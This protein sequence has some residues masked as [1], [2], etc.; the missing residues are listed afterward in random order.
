[1]IYTRRDPLKP[2][3]IVK[4][5]FHIYRKSEVLDSVEK[6]LNSLKN[7][8][9]I[10]PD[11]KAKPI[12]KTRCK[13]AV[14]KSPSKSTE[15]TQRS[16]PVYFVSR[17]GKIT[18]EEDKADSTQLVLVLKPQYFFID[19]T[20]IT[21]EYSISQLLKTLQS[22]SDIF[23]FGS[24]KVV[25]SDQIQEHFQLDIQAFRKRLS[26]F[27]LVAK[28]LLRRKTKSKLGIGKGVE[29]YIPF[30]TWA[31]GSLNS[32]LVNSLV[33]VDKLSQL[34]ICYGDN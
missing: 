2:S 6:A 34:K 3:E 23:E 16:R 9:G 1:M 22:L 10:V 17:L 19:R 21:H 30:R 13:G 14:R 4:K 27:V 20:I 31:R 8:V 32:Q 12:K 29:G 11:K 15:V 33:F 26:Q 28:A 24:G 18:L 25:F 5:Y 7:D